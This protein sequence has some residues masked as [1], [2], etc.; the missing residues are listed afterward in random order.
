MKIPKVVSCA[1]PLTLAFGVCFG[2]APQN[3]P[4]IDESKLVTLHGTLAPA[5]RHA[6]DLGRAVP[7]MPLDHMLLALKRSPEKEAQV[8]Q[9]LAALQDPKSPTYQH[10]MSATEFGQRFGATDAEIAQVTD[11]LRSH[12]LTVE[13]TSDARTMIQF[14]G[15][16]AQVEEAFHTEIHNLNVG[17]QPHISNMT[18]PQIPAALAGLVV[19]APLSDFKPHTLYK[20]AISV[21]RNPATGKMVQ[22]GKASPDYT[23]AYQGDQEYFVAP[24]DFA[25]IYNLN[26]LWKNGYRG[27]GQTVAVIEDTFMKAADVTTFRKAFGLSGYAGT[28]VQEAPAGAHPCSSPGIN[29]AEIEAALD[30][31]WAGATAPDAHVVLAACAD[32]RTQFGGLIALLNLLSQKTPPQVVSISYGECEAEMGTPQ[33]AQFSATYQQAVAEG[34]SL[35]VSSGDEG[36]VSCDANEPFAENGI[37]VSG[38]TSTPYDVSVGGTD[39]YDTA[40]G[41]SSKYW[42]K[43]NSATLTSALSYVPEKTWNNSC[44]D[45]TVLTFEGAKEAYGAT[46]FCNVYPGYEFVTTASGSGGPSSVYLKPTWQN[47]AGM[48]VDTSRDIPDVSMFASNGFWNHALLFCDSDPAEFGVACNYSNPTDAVYNSAGGTSF[49]SP[50]LAGIFTIITQKYGRQGNANPGFYKLAANEYGTQTTA[51]NASGCDST[52]GSAIGSTCVFNDV[53][54]G[55]IDVPCIYTNCF[56]WNAVPNPPFVHVT[57]FGALSLDSTQFTSAYP[58]TA[59]WDFATGLGSVN[60]LNLFNSWS[61]VSPVAK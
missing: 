22:V 48:P 7:D 53:T 9:T 21:Q 33:L 31:E 15:K 50:A 8:E 13:S 5:L 17:G 35:F 4:T 60:A 14:S 47:V 34:V 23:F 29:S 25:T 41:T 56:D 45:S 3:L 27:A 58:T 52:K 59:G 16:V 24:G 49:A 32:S 11:W 1:I 12:G 18:E 46:G 38:F 61:T 42:S 54:Q 40:Q 20:G 51:K 55:N 57:Y 6:E 10:W 28:F 39:F 44:A 2:Q 30:A 36:A 26:P 19:G 37:N 43:S